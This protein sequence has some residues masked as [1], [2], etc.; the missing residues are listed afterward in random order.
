[1]KIHFKR[2]MIFRFIISLCLLFPNIALSQIYKNVIFVSKKSELIEKINTLSL[3]SHVVLFAVKPCGGDF[4]QLCGDNFNPQSSVSHS[5]GSAHID[6]ES[7]LAIKKLQEQGVK[8]LIDMAPPRSFY[9]YVNTDPKVYDRLSFNIIDF[10]NHYNLDGFDYDFEPSDPNETN[11]VD[12]T[13]FMINMKD[14]LDGKIL[15]ITPQYYTFNITE[16][17]KV[18]DYRYNSSF[19]DSLDFINV[20]YYDVGEAALKLQNVLSWYRAATD[21]QGR[22]IPS[23]KLVLGFA[24][25]TND[26]LDR[27]MYKPSTLANEIIIPLLNDY[28]DSFGGV[29]AWRMLNNKFSGEDWL[30]S[31]HRVLLAYNDNLIQKNTKLSS[32]ANYLYTNDFGVMRFLNGH[33]KEESYIPRLSNEVELLELSNQNIAVWDK[34]NFLFSEKNGIGFMFDLFSLDGQYDTTV[35]KIFKVVSDEENIY[36]VTNVGVY[37]ISYD[38]LNDWQ[39]PKY[40]GLW[41]MPSGGYTD[42]TTSSDSLF[43]TLNGNKG[44]Y[45]YDVNTGFVEQKNGLPDYN[46]DTTV[47]EL[48]AI[49]NCLRV[50]VLN[51]YFYSKDNGR[52]WYSWNNMPAYFGCE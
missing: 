47:K 38:Y 13:S 31:I 5:W 39:D 42:A 35:N 22:N 48:L 10:I 49:K 21:L 23:K 27:W 18:Y 26:T 50:Q 2:T 11:P 40:I 17:K 9:K 37:E 8:V 24:L 32:N 34:S 20:Q 44:V 15:T 28:H 51:N 7:L 46:G 4:D 6:S 29:M 16:Y 52:N 1:M 43:V 25:G 36:V 41:N 30:N 3:A 12:M 45:R 19:I 33:W 14:K